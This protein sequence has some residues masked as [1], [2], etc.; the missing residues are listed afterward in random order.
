MTMAASQS[1]TSKVA[2][3]SNAHAR[4][5]DQRILQI[6]KISPMRHRWRKAASC[7][8]C[9]NSDSAKP[10][11]KSHVSG[12]NP[13][14]LF[15]GIPPSC[16]VPSGS[17]SAFKLFLLMDEER[18]RDGRRLRGFDRNH[19]TLHTFMQ[20]RHW[21]GENGIFCSSTLIASILQP[22]AP[23]RGRERKGGGGGRDKSNQ[24]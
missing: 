17:F 2:V 4:E 12:L 15:A 11:Q 16:E 9:R 14:A 22:S 8:C 6:A 1:G 10:R 20:R 7:T 13:A 19:S 18:N 23:E 24:D 5:G 21:D 3:C